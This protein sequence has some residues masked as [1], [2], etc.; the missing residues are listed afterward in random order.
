M[1]TLS[2]RRGSYLHRA[3]TASDYNLQ[4]ILQSFRYHFRA[5]NIPSKQLTFYSVTFG[6]KYI[7]GSY[8]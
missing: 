5:F 4:C 3:Y 1:A 2:Y 7:K 8:S 6:A